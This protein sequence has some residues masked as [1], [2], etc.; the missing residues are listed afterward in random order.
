M[1]G[2]GHT[3]RKRPWATSARRIAL[4]AVL[5]IAASALLPLVHGATSHASECAVCSVFAHNGAGVAEAVAPLDVSIPTSVRAHVP[6]EPVTVDTLRALDSSE[7]RAPPAPS[8][9][10]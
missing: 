4:V 5:A 6:L 10:I 8:A 2:E 9:S 1:T 3:I 7:A